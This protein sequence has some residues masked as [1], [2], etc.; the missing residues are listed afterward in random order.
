MCKGLNTR[1]DS[2]QRDQKKIK[3]KKYSKMKFFNKNILNLTIFSIAMGFMETAVVVYL[4]ELYYPH[5]FTTQLIGLS[6]RIIVTEVLREAATIIMLAMIGFMVGKNPAQR[7]G[8]FIYSFAIWDI[9]YYVF[10]KAILDWPS[11]LLSWD[12]LFLIP[13]PWIGPV[14]APVLISLTMILWTATIEQ[15]QNHITKKTWLL[16]TIASIIFITSFIWDYL[17]ALFNHIDVIKYAAMYEPHGYNW[18]VF[19]I[20][21]VVMLYGILSPLTPKGGTK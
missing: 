17:I 18:W 3:I 5:G 6:Q 8:Y 1:F 13:L 20:G 2:A 9:F 12:I 10:L 16:V 21:E 19:L 7:F 14:L 11:S 4:R 15:T